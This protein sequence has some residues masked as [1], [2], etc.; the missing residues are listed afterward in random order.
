M[1][2]WIN[3]GC[4]GYIEIICR[5]DCPFCDAAPLRVYAEGNPFPDENAY[6]T[7]L[8]CDSEWPMVVG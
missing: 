2:R 8:N 1:T 3:L 5:E 6:Y 4:G 7:C